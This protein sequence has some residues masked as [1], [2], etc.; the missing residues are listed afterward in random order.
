[1]LSVLPAANELLEARSVGSFDALIGLPS[2]SGLGL[3][4]FKVATRVRIPL[5]VRSK[6]VIARPSG[7][8]G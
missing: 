1:M 5:G 2:F 4:P 7:A 8:V 6:V 3:H